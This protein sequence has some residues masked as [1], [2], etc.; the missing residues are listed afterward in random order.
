MYKLLYINLGNP[1]VSGATTIVT[2]LLLR[3][4][5]RGVKV[6]LIELLFKEEEGL[7][8]RYP[9]LKEKVNVIQQLWDFNVT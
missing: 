3:L 1:T 5:M 2:E 6:D 4:P 8:G 9:E 7:L